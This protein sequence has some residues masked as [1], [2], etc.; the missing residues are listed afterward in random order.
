MFGNNLLF[1]N[2]YFVVVYKKLVIFILYTIVTILN[3]K[4]MVL[5]FCMKHWKAQDKFLEK[6]K[7]LKNN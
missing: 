3:L 6:S 2:L 5:T 7:T 1:S 4:S